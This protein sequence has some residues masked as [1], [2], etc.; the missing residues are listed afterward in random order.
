MR[1]TSQIH[2][3]VLRVRKKIRNSP[4]KIELDDLILSSFGNLQGDSSDRYINYE[5]LRQILIDDEV[6]E[7]KILGFEKAYNFSTEHHKE[8]KKRFDGTPF[9][10]HLDKVMLM[11]AVFGV[12]SE[13]ID[14]MSKAALHDVLDNLPKGVDRRKT[15]KKLYENFNASIV[16]DVVTM[17]DSEKSDGFMHKY[18]IRKQH[19]GEMLDVKNGNMDPWIIHVFDRLENHKNAEKFLS[20]P[21][22][23]MKLEESWTYYLPIAQ[24]LHPALGH[25][26][27][28]QLRFLRD[29]DSYEPELLGSTGS[30]NPVEI[31]APSSYMA[32]KAIFPEVPVQGSLNL[33]AQDEKD[34]AGEIILLNRNRAIETSNILYGS[35]FN[36]FDIPSTAGLWDVMNTNENQIYDSQPSWMCTILDASVET[37]ESRRLMGEFSNVATFMLQDSFT[38][39]PIYHITF[40]N[41]KEDELLKEIEARI[42]KMDGLRVGYQKESNP[43]VQTEANS[44]ALY[45]LPTVNSFLQVNYTLIDKVDVLN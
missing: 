23:R 32:L 16:D 12:T 17:S 11:I 1:M 3:E 29:S 14:L 43:Y 6:G 4:E 31:Y 19:M 13:T 30:V 45:F 35:I 9:Y 44:H 26:M 27:K 42:F 24:S 5:N 2:T 7:D 40:T 28:S 22:V 34:N 36:Q 10:F 20:V 8:N 15:Q 25:A 21:K 37:D 39:T 41:P 33:S 18:Q 38:N